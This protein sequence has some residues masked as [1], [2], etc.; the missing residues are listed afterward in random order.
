MFLQNKLLILISISSLFVGC[1]SVPK[2]DQ[3]LTQETKKLTAP[4]G[5]NAA[6]YVYRSNNIVGSALKKDIWVD[7]ECLGETARGVFFYKEIL[8]GQEH[9]ISTESE[10]SPN[11]L[12]LK[13]EA[14]KQYFVQQYIKPGV[15][16]GGA[17]LKVVDEAQG[18]NA[19]S[20]Y[21]LAQA[22]KCSHAKIDIAAV[23]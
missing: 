3:K 22:G 14:G 21:Q 23:K 7:G 13:T 10:F 19:I 15:F 9:I 5:E 16:V 11:H 17:N 1:A 20:E 4:V 6:I 12:K 2:A 18:R 8:G